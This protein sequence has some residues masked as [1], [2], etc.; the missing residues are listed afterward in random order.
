MYSSCV[1]QVMKDFAK[2]HLVV[3]TSM[4]CPIPLAFEGQIDKG[5]F[6]AV[7]LQLQN[8]NG[9]AQFD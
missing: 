8:H 4:L 1:E 3:K 7:S 9:F 5:D 6:L 2:D